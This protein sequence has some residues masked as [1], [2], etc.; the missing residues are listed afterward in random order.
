MSTA[1]RKNNILTKVFLCNK[2]TSSNM[3]TMYSH[4]IVIIINYCSF[5]LA[6]SRIFALNIYLM[7]AKCFTGNFFS[8]KKKTNYSK[9]S[10]KKIRILL[11]VTFSR[12]PTDPIICEVANSV[13]SDANHNKSP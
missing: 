5:F 13:A 6:F 9:L 12:F 2:R 11:L 10:R 1:G 8:G 4:R 3:R 7:P